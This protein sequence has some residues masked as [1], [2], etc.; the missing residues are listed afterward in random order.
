MSCSD[1]PQW[2][3]RRRFPVI[4]LSSS[5]WTKA[6]SEVLSPG[7]APGQCMSRLVE[8]RRIRRVGRGVFVV[9]DPVRETPSIA[10]AS[11]LFADLPHY[12]T[13][14]AALAFHGLIDQPISRIAVVLSMRRRPIKIGSAVVRPVVQPPDRI[15][16][17][18]AFDT[19]TDGFTVRLATREQA[20]VDALAEPAWM[21]HGDLLQE[22]LTALTPDE[23]DRTAAA[24]MARSTAAA[25]RLGYLLE[26]AGRAAPAVLEQLRPL[27]AVKLRPGQTIK[28]PYSTRW[29]VYG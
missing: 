29:R 10:I 4:D 5:T 8:A 25:Q 21:E 7:Y 20:I 12:V 2:Y 19:T 9:V 16:T 6:R 13:T 11:A 24:V 17:A 15:A 3:L 1:L 22:V 14:D 27:R 28:G 26:G 18:D 23:L